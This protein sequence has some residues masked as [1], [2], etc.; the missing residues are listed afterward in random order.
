MRTGIQICGIA[1]LIACAA[2]AQPNPPDEETQKKIIA[3]TAAKALSYSKELPDFICR[4]VTRRNEDPKGL[5]QW[6]TA[7]TINEQLTF[8]K[9]RE[10]YRTI[11]INGKKTSG[12]QNRQSGLIHSTELADYLNWI[13]D[14]KAKADI[15][16]SQ[17]DTLRGHRVH[18]LGYRVK[19]E[20]SQYVISRGKGQQF[21][22]GIFGVVSVDSE[23]GSILKVGLIATDVPAT[24]PIQGSAIEA[25]YEFAKIGDHYY[26]VPLKVDLHSKE[27]KMMIWNEVEFHDY[28]KP[29]A[30]VK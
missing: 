25:N 11:S 23:S 7:E 24:F 9:G 18:V 20:N 29:D 19:P 1:A 17:W 5:N 15:T 6:R 12:D 10:E 14:P 8:I 21:T 2:F 28:R 22:A 26:N 16:W 30:A 4:Q 3:E 13:F 27:G